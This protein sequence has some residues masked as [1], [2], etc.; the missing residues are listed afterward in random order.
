[1]TKELQTI[2]RQVFADSVGLP[3]SN[4]FSNLQGAADT[5]SRVGTALAQEVA[6]GSA[7]QKGAETALAEAGST[8]PR[9]LAPGLTAATKAYNNAFNDT[10]V[11][12]IA[13]QGQK[14]LNENALNATAPGKLNSN[15][16]ADFGKVSKGTI[17]GLLKTTPDHLKADVSIK[18]LG[19]SERAAGHVAEQVQS[20]NNRE[21]T[22]SL[23]L[24]YADSLNEV[25]V[26][27]TT[28]NK[29]QQSAAIRVAKENIQKYSTLQNITSAQKTQL[30]RTLDQTIINSTL[31]SGYTDAIQKDGE[32]GAVKFITKFISS[33]TPGISLVQKDLAKDFLLNLNTKQ[34]NN[35]NLASTQAF[36]NIQAQMNL[37]PGSIPTVSA[38][39]AA[40]VQQEQDGLPMNLAQKNKLRAQV[41][42]SNT[43]SSKRAQT[44]DNINRAIQN[45]S[46]EIVDFTNK[47]L[48]NFFLDNVASRKDQRDSAVASGNLAPGVLPD[49]QVEASVAAQVPVVIPALTKRLTAQFTNGNLTDVDAALRTYSYLQENNPDALKGLTDRVDAFADTLLTDVQNS[50]ND[51]DLQTIYDENKSAILDADEKVV[52]LRAQN[53]L[54]EVKANP[55]RNTRNI[56]KAY[57]IKGG[58]FSSGDVPDDMRVTYDKLLEKNAKL[59]ETKNYSLAQEKTISQLQG[60]YQESP[61]FAPGRPVPNPVEG[62]PFYGMG[63]GVQNQGAQTLNEIATNQAQFDEDLPQKIRLSEKMKRVPKTMSDEQ[64]FNDNLAEDGYWL[65]VGGVDSRIHWISPNFRSNEPFAPNVY[66][67]FYEYRG[68]DGKSKPVLRPLKTMQTNPNGRTQLGVT[69]TTMFPPSIYMPDIVEKLDSETIEAGLETAARDSLIRAN[70]INLKDFHFPVRPGSGQKGVAELKKELEE[71]KALI[72][73]RKDDIKKDLKSG[74]DIQRAKRGLPPI[75][76]TQEGAE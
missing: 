39:E 10:T 14:L 48:D 58:L 19:M 27:L 75:D 45:N 4:I 42:K 65:N 62:L 12:L 61:D 64:K 11:N 60:V 68:E 56:R 59:Y 43:A 30:E 16:L 71:R 40:I 17:E 29:R 35:L 55:N 47:E 25:R 50:G 69:M 5:V 24:Q 53:H 13:L 3:K 36:N 49:W 21:I 26:A 34:R 23:N 52:Q 22:D 37:E 20:F 76:N 44:N 15:S 31:E 6:V 54:K 66:Q 28:G 7:A 41:R 72:A 2:Q 74:I 70:P 33:D 18:L 73:E 51:R 9:K 1:M 67:I 57:G 38:L 8:E 63:N 46:V 32:D